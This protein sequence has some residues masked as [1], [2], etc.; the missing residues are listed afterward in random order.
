MFLL[1]HFFQAFNSPEVE[2]SFAEPGVFSV[3]AAGEAHDSP[4]KNA[5]PHN[6]PIHAADFEKEDAG[7]ENDY[8]CHTCFLSSHSLYSALSCRTAG[9]P[10]FNLKDQLHADIPTPPPDVQIFA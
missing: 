6:T 4:E 8:V 2:Y 9:K 10:F 1:I 3:S 7:T 5:M